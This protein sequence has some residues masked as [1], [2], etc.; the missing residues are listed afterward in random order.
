M[1]TVFC[2]RPSLRLLTWPKYVEDDKTDKSVKN[3]FWVAI[4][5]P[6]SLNPPMGSLRSSPSSTSDPLNLDPD[7]SKG[8]AAQ[9]IRRRLSNALWTTRATRSFNF[10]GHTIE[11]SERKCSHESVC[12]CVCVCVCVRERERLV[13]GESGRMERELALFGLCTSTTKRSKG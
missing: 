10:D 4:F 7:W 6:R 12:V 1:L 5:I 8:S 13:N 9:P 2:V 11:Q 3:I